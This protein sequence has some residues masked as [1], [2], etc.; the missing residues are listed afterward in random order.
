MMVLSMPWFIFYALLVILKPYQVAKSQVLGYTLRLTGDW[1]IYLAALQ[2]SFVA[3]FILGALYGLKLYKHKQITSQYIVLI[4]CQ[5]LFLID[6][7][8]Y[9]GLATA[10]IPVFTLTE[11][12]GF[13][14]IYYGFSKPTIDARGIRR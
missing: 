6:G 8:T 1:Y 5:L 3:I 12:F 2:V 13:L 14:G 4:M 11:I 9:F 7:F 10:S